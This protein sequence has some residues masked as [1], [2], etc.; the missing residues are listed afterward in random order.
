MIAPR[1]GGRGRRARWPGE[2]AR[3]PPRGA[4]AEPRGQGRGAGCRERWAG[5]PA[6]T[7]AAGG[8]QR[9]GARTAAGGSR[10]NSKRLPFRAPLTSRPL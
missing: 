1:A 5:D 9:G 8:W 7:P 10:G 2:A 6:E 4:R 3:R